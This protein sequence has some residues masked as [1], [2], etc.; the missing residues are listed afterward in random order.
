MADPVESQIEAAKARDQS[1]YTLAYKNKLR[2]TAAFEKASP[3]E[4]KAMRQA[5]KATV[6]RQRYGSNWL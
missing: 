6:E 4:K 3:A 5:V 1:A 2:G